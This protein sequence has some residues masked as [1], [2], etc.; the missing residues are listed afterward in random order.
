M[1]LMASQERQLRHLQRTSQPQLHQTTIR[2]YNTISSARRLALIADQ[3]TSFLLFSDL[4][5]LQRSRT[6][7][8]YWASGRIDCPVE[9]RYPSQGAAQD[10]SRPHQ[11]LQETLSALIQFHIN[12]CSIA[13]TSGFICLKGVLLITIYSGFKRL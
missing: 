7:A 13:L 2:D 9:V 3:L 4:S 10:I 12:V 5:S 1:S 8:F 11:R 6:N